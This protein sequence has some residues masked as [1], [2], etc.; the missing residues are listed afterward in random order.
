VKKEVD[1]SRPQSGRGVLFSKPQRRGGEGEQPRRVRLRV[2]GHKDRPKGS[3][4]V[5]QNEDGNDASN[6]R[7]SGRGGTDID[8]G[9]EVQRTMH[10]TPDFRLG[11]WQKKVAQRD[12]IK[13]N[14]LGW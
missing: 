12:D 14:Q 7:A 2:R 1:Q 9:L 4:N 10:P 11:D 5:N 3:I 8:L 6:K 13:T